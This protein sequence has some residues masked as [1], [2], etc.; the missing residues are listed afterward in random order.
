M[1]TGRRGGAHLCSAA[2]SSLRDKLST[3]RSRFPSRLYH[4]ILAPNQISSQTQASA[5]RLCFDAAIQAAQVIRRAAAYGRKRELRGCRRR[6]RA[7]STWKPPLPDQLVYVS[8]PGCGGRVGS[9][10]RSEPDHA[11]LCAPPNGSENKSSPA[12]HDGGDELGGEGEAGSGQGREEEES[13]SHEG[14]MRARGEASVELQGVQRLPAWEEAPSVQGVWRD[15]NL[16]ARLC[17]L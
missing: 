13:P 11:T 3:H 17:T 9:Y 2:R 16:R 6:A 12:Q 10:V 14:A 1:G 15:I 7:R 5:F 4:K 8:R